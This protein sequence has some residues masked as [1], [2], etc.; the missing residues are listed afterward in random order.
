MPHLV[1]TGWAARAPTAHA[2]LAGPAHAQGEVT[3]GGAIEVIGGMSD[4]DNGADGF[5]RGLFSRIVV[6]YSNSLDSGLTISGNISYLVNQGRTGAL[7]VS[8]DNLNKAMMEGEMMFDKNKMV[9]VSDGFDSPWAPDVLSISVGG[10]FGTVTMGHHAMASCAVMPRVIAFVPG[11]V[12]TTWYGRFSPLSFANGTFSESNYCGTPT[13]ISYSTPS[14][15]GLSAMVSFAPNKNADQTTALRGEGAKDAA[16]NYLA[17]A[18][19]F[20]TDMGGMSVSVGGSFQT[21]EDDAVDSVAV[22][23]TVGMAGGTVGFSWYDNGDLTSKDR[24]GTEGWNVGAKYSLGAITPAITYSQLE[25]DKENTE[26]SAL[27][28]GAGYAVGGGFNVFVEYMALEID[29]PGTKYDDEDTV[30]MTGVTLGF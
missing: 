16:E 12:N 10:G 5:D 8:G 1:C 25:S 13:G 9:A 3:V 15:G 14:M 21:A 2:A 28:I 27:A 19:K 4:H 23:A 20:S 26:E 17:A 6:G 30:L 24:G 18:A 11:G 22:A 7:Q 29:G